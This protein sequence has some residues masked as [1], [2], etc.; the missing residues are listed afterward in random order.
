M[1]QTCSHYVNSSRSRWWAAEGV[2]QE[3]KR[4]KI[5]TASWKL[6]KVYPLSPTRALLFIGQARWRVKFQAASPPSWRRWSALKVDGIVLWRAYEPGG[7]EWNTTNHHGSKSAV[8]DSKWHSWIWILQYHGRWEH[9]CEQHCTACHVNGEWTRKWQCAR[10]IGMKLVAQ[11]NADTIVV[12]IKYELLCMNL[13]IQDACG[14]CYDGCS[15]MTGTKM[16]LL[17]K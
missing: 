4:R 2:A 8:L 1:S 13:R 16:R 15:T 14:Q 11:T 10:Y 17:L 7:S 6:S 12:C 5:G 9:W 3:S